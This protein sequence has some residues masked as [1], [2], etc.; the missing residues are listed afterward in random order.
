[1]T[2][3]ADGDELQIVELS[4]SSHPPDHLWI[5]N[6]DRDIIWW[7]DKQLSFSGYDTVRYKVTDYRGGV[8]EATV[9]FALRPNK[10]GD[11]RVG[12]PAVYVVD[13]RFQQG[14][15]PWIASIDL[16]F[17]TPG[18]PI[19]VQLNVENPTERDLWL[20][21]PE[22]SSLSLLESGSLKVP[23][24]GAGQFQMT[25]AP[26][27]R[28]SRIDGTIIIQSDDPYRP[29]PWQVD[30]KGLVGDFADGGGI[31]DFAQGQDI[32]LGQISGGELAFSLKFKN[33]GE[34]N[35]I[36]HTPILPARAS[37]TVLL[38]RHLIP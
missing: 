25:L 18:Q 21:S 36:L 35:L 33:T 31:V 12:A 19:P 9:F 1:M 34:S 13:G 32:D 3:D 27:D 37:P 10:A 22:S 5:G 30:I 14:P 20:H 2:T 6:G 26:L 11:F 16:G 7:P 28:G 15:R 29:Y 4:P 38:F 8:S 17:V 23:S 24:G